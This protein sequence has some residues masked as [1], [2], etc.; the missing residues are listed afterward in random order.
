MKIKEFITQYDTDNYIVPF[1]VK[2]KIP[3]L[4][5]LEISFSN[6]MLSQYDGNIKINIDTN[7]RLKYPRFS[8]W[9]SNEDIIQL[10]CHEIGHFISNQIGY[11]DPIDSLTKR[12]EFDINLYYDEISV[13]VGNFGCQNR[14]PCKFNPVPWGQ[15]EFIAE[16]FRLFILDKNIEANFPNKYKFITL[17]LKSTKRGWILKQ[18]EKLK[19]HY[20]F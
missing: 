9:T 2:Y 19:Y 3:N 13:P 1:L 16:A 14:K 5:K 7:F 8:D 20:N 4:D 11:V 18:I 10:F 6:T 15:K 12:E 17:I